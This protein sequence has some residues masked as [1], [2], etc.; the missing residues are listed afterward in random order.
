MNVL[1]GLTI[2][3]AIIL[4]AFAAF[5]G[6]SRWKD[7]TDNVC[8][9]Y[10]H[11]EIHAGNAYMAQY[12]ADFASGEKN[13]LLINTPVAIAN[14]L[15]HLFIDFGSQGEAYLQVWED[16]TVSALGGAQRVGNHNKAVTFTSGVAVT[17]GPTIIS[18]GTHLDEFDLHHGSG[19]QTGDRSRHNS[20]IIL[21][22]S[23]LYLINAVSEAA[24]NEIQVI[25]H[26][27]MSDDYY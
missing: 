7:G 24:A 2:I 15:T 20:E 26:F 27:Y 16:T 6:D 10:E 25:L 14:G 13:Q 17:N 22:E 4:M 3:L 21:A 5:A 18:A 12:T 19:K 23:K 11:H 9:L 1:K 8:T